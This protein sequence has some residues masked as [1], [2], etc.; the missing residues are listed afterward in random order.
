MQHCSPDQLALA[1]LREELPAEDAAHLSGCATC[2]AEVASL[3]RGV[4]AL[5]VPAFSSAGAEVAPPPRVWDAIAAATGA[6]SR[7]RPTVPPVKA[8]ASPVPAPAPAGATAEPAGAD[9]VPLRPR[10][11]GWSRNRWLT[12]AAAVLV[13]AV[14]GGT[15]VALTGEDTGGSVVAETALDPLDD[16]TASGRAQVREDGGVRSLQID[17]DAPALDDGYYEVWLLEPDAVRMVPLGTVR[18]GDSVLPVPEGLDL[19]A[20]PVVDVSIEP[21][22]GDPTHSGV[23]VVRG[24]LSD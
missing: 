5:A 15:V 9:V 18:T 19:V 11:G 14:A 7:P 17:L 21:L 1:A 23:S 16:R 8:A 12:A 24:Q 4:D 22:D 13:G 6:T 3:Q 10:A 2:Q 20:Y